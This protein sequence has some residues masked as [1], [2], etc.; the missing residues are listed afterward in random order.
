MRQ[1]LDFLEIY[2]FDTTL[3][4]CILEREMENLYEQHVENS[5]GT[6]DEITM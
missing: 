3:L 6:E 1:S 5:Y 4:L 2:L